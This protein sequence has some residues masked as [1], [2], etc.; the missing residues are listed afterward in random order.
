MKETCGK[1]MHNS[2]LRA[3]VSAAWMIAAFMGIEVFM[4]H[5]VC[6]DLVYPLM[7]SAIWAVL[8]TAIV[9]ILPRRAARIVFGIVYYVFMTY[10]IA[11]SIYYMIFEKMMW[12]SD[13]RYAGEGAEFASSVFSFLTKGFYISFVLLIAI[14]VVGIKLVPRGRRPRPRRLVCLA[15]VIVSIVGLYLL[16]GYVFQQ[17]EDLWGGQNEYRRA[18]SLEGTYDVMYDARK[19]YR[20]CGLY[21]YTMRDIYKHYIVPHLPAYAEELEE[22]RETIDEFFASRDDQESNEMTGIFEGKNVIFVLMESM[23]D[24]LISDELTP[25]ISQMM[26]EGINFTNMYTPGYGGVRTFN[27]EFCVMTG[28]YLPTDGNLAFSY[29]TNDFSQS[30]ANLFRAE[31]YTANTFHY[32][33]SIFYNRGVMHPAVGFE[34]YVSYYDYVEDSS[35]ESLLSDTFMLDN[36]AVSNLFFGEDSE[37]GTFCS[38]LITRA[39]HMPYTYDDELSQYALELYPEFEGS[40]G[41]EETDCLEAKAKLVDDMFEELLLQLEENG[42]LDDTVIV[43]FTDHYAYGMSNKDLLYEMSGVDNSLLLEKTPCFIWANDIESIEVDKTLNTSDILPTVLNL[44]G[45]Q[46]QYDYLGQDAFD[47]SYD[48][49]V[50]FPSGDWITNEVV[51]YEGKIIQEFYDGALADVDTDEMNSLAEAYI[52]ISNLLLKCDYYAQDDGS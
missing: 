30:L 24:W 13:I 31:G 25:T 18:L 42:H 4:R 45:L 10:A 5:Y 15:G 12:L 9:Q 38:F 33:Q 29:C 46:D 39:A 19:V 41:D 22:N 23:D 37:N 26:D 11:Q 44:F 16:P 43:A 14:G 1:L 52:N 21:Q 35:D 27:T 28:I 32:N 51:Y 3:A 40:T 36:D 50:I 6:S 17:D 20:I 8:L 48:G 47:D 49:Y 34:E 7:F 2:R